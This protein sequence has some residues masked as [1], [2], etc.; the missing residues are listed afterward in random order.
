MT[1]LLPK[2]NPSSNDPSISPKSPIEVYDTTLRDGSQGEGVSFSLADKL[3][4]TRMMDSLGIHFIEGGWPGSNPKDLEYFRAV[5]GLKLEHSKVAAF[6]ST[7]HAK[8]RASEDLNLRQLAS[9]RAA[10]VTIVGKSWDMNVREALR[11][12]LDENLAMIASSIAYLKDRTE[13]VFFDAE[14]FFDGFNE[15]PEYALKALEAAADAG[16]GA[17]I[18]CDTNGG[19]LPWRIGEITARVVAHF[20]G[21]PIG[22]HAHNDSGMAVANTLEAVRAGAAQVQGTLNGFGERTGNADLVQILANLELKMGR[23]C[24]GAERLKRLT[25]LSRYTYEAANLPP[26]DN[27]PF[28]GRSAFAHKGGLHVSAVSRNPA[29]Y[30]H[31]RPEAVGN[32]RRVLVSELS[33]RSNILACA[34]VD[35]REDPEKARQVLERLMELENRG[36]AFENAE[37][38]FDLLVRRVTGSHRP[39]FKLKT[40][41]VISEFDADGRRLSEAT[42]RVAVNGVVHHVAGEGEHGPVSALDQALRRALVPVY[43]VLREMRLVDYKVHIVNA[44]AA[45]EAKVRVVIRSADRSEV[46]STVGVS[47]NIIEASCLAL[48]DSIESMLQR[49][50]GYESGSGEKALKL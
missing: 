7:R 31:V 3:N 16:A 49:R 33:G 35:L 29:T 43:P 23:H 12:S 25:E 24:V 6:G 1:E 2:R 22:I 19:N 9:A 42:I 11:V 48:V 40:A 5:R 13:Q 41:R 4:L 15:N 8:N 34:N 10:V 37:A 20:S 50:I 47:E 26:R 39:F 17:L 30:E 38:S 32:E 28:V 45:A 18:L 36:Y 27:Q 14:H 44:K 46:W 21:L